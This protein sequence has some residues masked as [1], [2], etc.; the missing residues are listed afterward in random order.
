MKERRI[1]T[2]AW[3]MILVLSLTGCAK[4]YHG[5][6][7][8]LEKAREEMEAAGLDT[9]GLSFEC[10]NGAGNN[11]VAWFSAESA[12][13]ERIYFPMEIKIKGKGANY[14]FIRSLEPAT[15]ILPI[16]P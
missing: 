9:D 8:L 12:E 3:L 14:V 5:T 1:L 16:E 11:A 15:D 7:A 4:V 2:A 13:G 10:M 6:D